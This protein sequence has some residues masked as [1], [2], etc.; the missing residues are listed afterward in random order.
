MAELPEDQFRMCLADA[1]L[2]IRRDE[3]VD[4]PDLVSD[5]PEL[6]EHTHPW[7]FMPPVILVGGSLAWKFQKISASPQEDG[8]A[9]QFADADAALSGAGHL[10]TKRHDLHRRLVRHGEQPTQDGTIIE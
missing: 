4:F 6:A 1:D 3:I 2:A 10:E 5:I 7:A 9:D 8:G